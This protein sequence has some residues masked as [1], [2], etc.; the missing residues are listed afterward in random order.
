LLLYIAFHTF[1]IG[2]C[3]GR[4]FE[5]LLPVFPPVIPI[6]PGIH[7]VIELHHER[8]TIFLFGARIGFAELLGDFILYV[9]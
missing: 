1:V 3:Y 7:L 4:R 8:R 2:S 6:A 9:V 5:R